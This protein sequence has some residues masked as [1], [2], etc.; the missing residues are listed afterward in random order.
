MLSIRWD[1]THWAVFAMAALAA[2]S[3]SLLAFGVVVAR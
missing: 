1:A 3:T 2:A